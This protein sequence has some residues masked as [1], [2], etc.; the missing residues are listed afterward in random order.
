MPKSCHQISHWSSLGWNWF[1]GMEAH[2][3]FSLLAVITIRFFSFAAVLVLWVMGWVP[4]SL[5]A[6][7]LFGSLVMTITQWPSSFKAS[8]LKIEYLHPITEAL[9]KVLP[10]FRFRSI[11]RRLTCEHNR[12]FKGVLDWGGRGY[13]ALHDKGALIGCRVS[14][15]AIHCVFGHAFSLRP[16]HAASICL[17][18]LLRFKIT[19]TSLGQLAP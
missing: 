1:A 10:G 17:F 2:Y 18:V 6:S 15:F 3:L 12:Q 19:S 7:A 14:R 8:F 16:V 9:I 11:E 13:L 5:T 4:S